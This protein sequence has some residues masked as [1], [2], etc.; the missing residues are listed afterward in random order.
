MSDTRPIDTIRDGNLK[1][2]IWKNE[3]ENGPFLTTTIT[4][5]YTDQRGN[6][7]DTASF[8]G[9]ELLRVAELSRQAY[10]R[11]NELRRELSLSADR[12]P[13]D[14]RRQTSRSFE[15][16]ADRDRTRTRRQPR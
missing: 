8:T 7:H 6:Y 14:G 11:S 16:Q 2:S 3:G 13:E 5:T 10:S 15:R 9:T 12:E 4:R 1:A